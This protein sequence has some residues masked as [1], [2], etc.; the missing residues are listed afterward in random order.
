ME[1]QG[2]DRPEHKETIHGHSVYCDDLDLRRYLKKLDQE[3]AKAIF[4][5]A[6]VHG[7]TEFEWRKLNSNTRLNCTME[8]DDGA[9]IVRIE[10]K[11]ETGWI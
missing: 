11:E 8:Y 4:D 9:Y 5:Y 10:G 6:R 7:H 3:E 1:D 2:T